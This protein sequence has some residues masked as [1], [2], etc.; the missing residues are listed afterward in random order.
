MISFDVPRLLFWGVDEP[1]RTH[2]A[3]V[4]MHITVCIIAFKCHVQWRWSVQA[5]TAPMLH[6]AHRTAT[7]RCLMFDKAWPT[8]L[9][10]GKCMSLS[11]RS[12]PNSQLWR[13]FLKKAS[14]FRSSYIHVC[15]Y[16]S[17][18]R[19]NMSWWPNLGG[20]GWLAKT[21]NKCVVQVLAWQK[22]ALIK[23]KY[24]CESP[25]VGKSESG[26]SHSMK[27]SAAI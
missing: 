18:P 19:V 16:L 27:G 4:S 5:F 24:V 13:L 15:S 1:H 12:I 25:R 11:L 22:L 8:K 26:L 10:S 6:I 2:I 21:S 7:V 14:S 9:K 3:W 23:K 20:G 17:S